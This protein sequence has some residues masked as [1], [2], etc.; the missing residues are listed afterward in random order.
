[1]IQSI[2]E[3]KTGER[4]K[5]KKKVVKKETIVEESED[6]IAQYFELKKKEEEQSIA[7]IE[8]EFTDLLASDSKEEKVEDIINDELLRIERDDPVK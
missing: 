5:S 1:L 7:A 2:K 6:E 4:K 8:A 3:R